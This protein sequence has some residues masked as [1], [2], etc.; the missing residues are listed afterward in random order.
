M[1]RRE[2]VRTFGALGAGSVAGCGEGGDG[3]VVET[4]S[5]TDTTA[6]TEATPTTAVAEPTTTNDES[7]FTPWIGGHGGLHLFAQ[8]G[9]LEVEI[10]ATAFDEKFPD[11]GWPSTSVTEID[12]ILAAPDREVVAETTGSVLEDP[13]ASKEGDA[14]MTF[15]TRVERP[16]VYVVNVTAAV[17][18]KGTNVAWS[19]RTNCDEFLIETATRHGQPEPIVLRD[20]DRSE[21]VWFQPTDHE[22]NIDVSGLPTST[23]EVTLNDRSGAVIETLSVENGSTSTTI[24]KTDGWREQAPW[25]LQLPNAR[26]KI[27]VDGVTRWPNDD[28]PSADMVLWTTSP[29]QWLSLEPNRWLLRPYRRQVYGTPGE[30]DSQTF[31]VLNNGSGTRRFDLNLVKPGQSWDVSLSDSSLELD[32]N[33][34]GTVTLDFAFPASANQERRA[35]LEISPTEADVSTYASLTASTERA[36][37]KPLT[38][39]LELEPYRHENAK[40]G[41]RAD[42]PT[43]WEKYTDLDNRPS[44]RVPGGIETLREGEWRRTDFAETVESDTAAFEGTPFEL[45]RSNTKIAFDADNDIYLVGRTANRAAL[46]HSSDGGRSFTAYDLGRRGSFDIEQF[47]GHNVPDRPPTLLRSVETGRDPDNHWRRFFDLEV[48][49]VQKENG[50]LSVGD[51]VLLADTS[52]GVSGHSG[53]PS[54][55]VSRDG[56]AHVIWGETTD[57][58]EDA[59]GVPAYVQSYDRERQELLGSPELIGYGKP[60]NDIHNRSSITMDSEGYLHALAGTHGEPFQYARSKSPNTAHEGWTEAEPV[61]EG[62]HQTYIGLVCDDADTLHLAYRLWIYDDY[63]ID[64]HAVLAYQRKPAG[65]SWTEP[66]QLVVSPFGGYSV[67]YHR[68]TIDRQDRLHLS[69]DY[70]SSFRFYRH[71]YPATAGHH[72]TTMMSSDGGDTW[73]LLR[74]RDFRN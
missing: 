37:A 45:D 31:T 49:P 74:T 51:P 65:E 10:V 64:H 39:P 18:Q 36:E 67:F 13:T 9:D 62:L 68:L 41:Y 40:F 25:G 52:I 66:R 11:R 46:L 4:E 47:S 53:V 30:S 59:P 56:I 73:E 61:G 23:D 16:G 20:P 72:R 60:A 48:I 28:D 2:F 44:V 33:E 32:A 21:T 71:D 5:P 55:V 42:Y 29:D 69:Y 19:A 54:A 43:S 1:D 38:T 17:D 27:H 3:G 34:E 58:E 6:S 26:G 12:A 35:V 14:V 63:P 7:G 57:P 22:T 50:R 70:W 8:P 15:S 24:P